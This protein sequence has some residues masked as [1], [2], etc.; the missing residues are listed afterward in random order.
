MHEHQPPSRRRSPHRGRAAVGH[1]R[2]AVQAGPAVAGSGLAH[3][4]ALRPGCRGAAAGGAAPGR[5]GRGAATPGGEG[6]GLRGGRVRGDG[7]RAERRDHPDQRHARGAADRGGTGAGRGHR[8]AVAP[9]RSPADRVAGLRGL[10][11]RDRP[12]HRRRRRRGRERARRRPGA[13]LAGAVGHVHRGAGAAAARAGPGRGHRGSVPRCRAGCAGLHGGGR[14]RAGRPGPARP[15]TGRGRARAGR[16][17]GAVHAVR[18]RAEPGASPGGRGLPQHR[19]AG[20]CHRR[21]HVLRR[22]GGPEAGGRGSGRRGG[23]RVE[24][25]FGRVSRGTGRAG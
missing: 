17:A 22:P 6:S 19:A 7:H 24:C 14:G 2:A 18:L 21:R 10:A 20:R 11:G 25:G 15:R 3:R 16:D 9:G 1:H 5:P 4:R 23:D 12:G 13:G 8:R